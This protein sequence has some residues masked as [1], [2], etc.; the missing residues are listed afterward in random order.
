MTTE[1]NASSENAVAAPMVRAVCIVIAAA[2]LLSLVIPAIYAG[3]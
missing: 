3:L 2:M 1:A